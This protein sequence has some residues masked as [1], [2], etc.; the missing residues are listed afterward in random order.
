MY[1]RLELCKSLNFS[2]HLPLRPYSVS[3]V[4]LFGPSL[5]HFDSAI[6]SFNI[7]YLITHRVVRPTLIV[8]KA[9]ARIDKTVA[10]YFSLLGC[11]GSINVGLCELLGPQLPKKLRITGVIYSRNY[12]STDIG[13]ANGN[14]KVT[15]VRADQERYPR[16]PRVLGHSDW[17]KPAHNPLPTPFYDCL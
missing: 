1:R 11:L 13:A 2:N 16:L 5:H 6:N 10:A 7:N 12:P 4:W 8:F 17:L 9:V 3:L 15:T 14:Q